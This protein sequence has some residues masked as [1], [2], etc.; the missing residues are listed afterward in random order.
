MYPRGQA[1]SSRRIETNFMA[2]AL[3]SGTVALALAVDSKVQALALALKAALTIF[4]HHL[5]TQER[6]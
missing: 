5:Q 2:L 4:W 3:A 6:Q 1:L